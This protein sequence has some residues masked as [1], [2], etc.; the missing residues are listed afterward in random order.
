MNKILIAN[1]GEIALRIMRSC[2]TLGI[3]TVAVYSD[4]DFDSLHVQPADEAYRLGPAPVEHSYLNIESVLEAA[5][6][7]GADGVHPG[8]G[9]L[10]ENA[11]FATAVQDA[12]LIWIGPSPSSMEKMGSKIR[13][14]EIAS[15][16]DVPVTPAIT[17]TADASIDCPAIL[18]AVGLPLMIKS[19]AGG[20]GIG[21]REVHTEAEL[22]AALG[23]VREHAN[24]QFGNGD[25]LVEKLLTAGRHVEVQV[26]GDSRGNLLHLFERDCSAQRRRQKILEE[27]PAPG[28]AD[29]T[30]KS[31][32]EAALS[33]AAAVHYQGVGTVEFLLTD[34]GFYLLEMNTRL[35][36]EHP[37]TEAVTGLDL[38]ALQIAIARGEAL[39][40][41]QEDIH[42]TGHAIEARVYAEDPALGFVPASGTISSFSFEGHADVR[43]DSGVSKGSSVGHHYDGM[44][45][46]V[47]VHAADRESATSG[48]RDALQQLRLSGIE[49]NQQFLCTVLDS[50]NWSR[51]LQTC[52]IENELESLLESGVS[53]PENIAVA[54]VAATIWQFLRYP[55]AAD[56][57]PWPGGYHSSRLT[58]WQ[59]GGKLYDVDWRWRAAKAFEF[60]D[61]AVSASVV[62]EDGQ[63]LV[64]EINGRQRAFYLQ[65][66]TAQL[67]LWESHLGN[68]KL[69][70]SRDKSVGTD[71]PDSRDC[72]SHGPGQVL[73]VLVKQ[74]QKV[75]HNEPLVVVESMK[76]ESTLRSPGAGTVNRIA[77]TE[78]EVIASGQILVSLDAESEER[79]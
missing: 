58:A 13:S 34:D 2:D 20:G 26:V 23:E 76:M 31:L 49:T 63:R 37:V 43:V 7:S 28:L 55:P 21:M 18:S 79:A 67:W 9:F 75:L 4:A 47:I 59:M 48:L 65:Y 10:S 27:A 64:I 74:G 60:E 3:R 39:S 53:S 35:Q 24:R 11:E 25:L 15:A 33:L 46:K 66:D 62:S 17:L 77:V 1:R 57:S 8:Y 16:N 54:L 50:P 72:T 5:R 29:S 38:V 6:Q 69:Q 42:C 56:R 71:T 41:S 12:G 70:L 78:G 19:S 51:C 22:E 30:R 14:R 73:R 40:L 68:L 44:L 36:V 45:C 52:T 61:L 32:Q